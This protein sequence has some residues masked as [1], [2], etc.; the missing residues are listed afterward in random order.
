MPT[1]TLGRLELKQSTKLV[2]GARPEEGPVNPALINTTTV[3]HRDLESL[4][5]APYQKAYG[6]HGTDTRFIAE[7]F[8]SEI[9]G[10]ETLFCPS[11]VSA[12]TL[13]LKAVAY[14]GDH[15]LVADNCYGNTR[16][17]CDLVLKPL[18][19]D[20]EYFDSTLPKN[21]IEKKLRGNTSAIFLE[22]PG[23]QTMEVSDVEGIAKLAHGY[24]DKRPEIDGIKPPIHVIADTTYA[25]PLEPLPEGVDIGVQAL[26]KYAIGHS[27]AFMGAVSTN[28]KELMGHI[29]NLYKLDGLAVSPRD[30]EQVIQGMRTLDVR[31]E[32]HQKNALAL[33]K[34][35]AKIPEVKTVLHPGLESCPGHEYWKGKRTNGLFSI[36][37]NEKLSEEELAAFVK[38]MPL[39]YSW[40]GTE[41]IILPF[42][43][44]RT[45]TQSDGNRGTMIRI[46]AGLED[47]SDL[48]FDFRMAFHRLKQQKSFTEREN[49]RKTPSSRHL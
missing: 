41:H 17:F 36:E 9:Q 26:T 7:E 34:W 1:A 48:K 16:D 2:T 40:G 43:P 30:C 23:S 25:T 39:G 37:L 4:R 8:F 38:G 11:G 10:T 42:E 28:D 3:I 29:R 6:R 22:S 19:V 24:A 13:A 47:L 21:E 27:N 49:M 45:A 14:P 35:F 18:G 12:I 31:M 32:R 5:A 15:L 46:H 20:V 33:A 44:H